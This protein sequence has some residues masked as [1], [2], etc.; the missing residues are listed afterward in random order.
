MKGSSRVQALPD[1]E[2]PDGSYAVYLLQRELRNLEVNIG[3]M[4]DDIEADESRL[5][6]A[7]ERLTSA[8]EARKEIRSAI[9]VLGGPE[10]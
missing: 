7:R 5:A 6:V 2:M 10:S 4:Q 8:I 1:S 9:A 3:V